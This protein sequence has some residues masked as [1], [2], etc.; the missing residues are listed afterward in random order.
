MKQREIKFR[1]WYDGR[2]IKPV[3]VD[4][5]GN[6]FVTGIAYETGRGY[7][8]DLMQYTGLRDKNGKE[9]YEG[10]I[11]IFKCDEIGDTF[12]VVR[13]SDQGIWTSQKNSEQEEILADELHA[14]VTE[15]VGNI[16]ET[17]ELCPQ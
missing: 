3:C 8:G 14:F 1:S 9:I 6:W 10:D 11:L 5:F 4:E 15:V 12:G 17:P 7:K 13:F 16:F 2:M